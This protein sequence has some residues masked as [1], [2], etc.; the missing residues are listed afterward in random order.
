MKNLDKPS[1]PNYINNMKITIEGI[2]YEINM[3]KAKELGICTEIRE[4][5]ESFNVGDVFEKVD[6]G[7]NVRVLISQ[8]SHGSR[9][10]D[11]YN[12]AG[13][14]GLEVYSDF[15]DR[16]ISEKELLKWLNKRE[17]KFVKNI[18]KQISNLIED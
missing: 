10:E 15:S 3:Q 6:E 2:N 17:Y 7:G 1:T 18:N 16:S 11:K 12:I 5:I 9:R 13:C 4:Q 14:I 8:S